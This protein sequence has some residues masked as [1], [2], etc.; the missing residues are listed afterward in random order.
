MIQDDVSAPIY[1]R[2]STKEQKD[3]DSLHKPSINSRGTATPDPFHTQN[4]CYY[5]ET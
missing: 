2:T 5:L 4:L 1:Q 3:Y